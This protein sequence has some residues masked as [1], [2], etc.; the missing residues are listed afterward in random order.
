MPTQLLHSFVS[1]LECS[2]SSKRYDPGYLYNISDAGRPLLVRYD[3]QQLKNAIAVTDLVH[4]PRDIWRYEELL[5]VPPGTEI[6]SLGE[7]STP[8]IPLSR[9]AAKTE[10][11]ELLLKDESR[12]PNGTA[13]ARDLAVAVT[14]AKALGVKHLSMQ[15][16]GNEG[17]TLAAY[18]SRAG[19]NATIVCSEDTPDT[20]IREMT[21]YGA[22]IRLVAGPSVRRENIMMKGIREYGW[23]DIS[24]LREPYRLEGKKTI[25]FELAEQL[26]W[27]LPDV[28]FYPTGNGAGLIAIW[29]AFHELEAIGWI[30]AKRPRMIAVQPAGCAPIV[31]AFEARKVFLE[32][33]W[34]PVTTDIQS[35][36]VPKPFGDFLCLQV[37]QDSGGCGIMISDNE[38]RN[39]L[40]D[41]ALTEGIYLGLEGALCL[42]AYKKILA[43]G[44]IS[45][46]DQVVIFN[47]AKIPEL[48]IPKLAE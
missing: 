35:L 34:G 22:K 25:G 47:S 12:M 41:I 2:F 37:I 38:A 14:M 43:E 26:D 23:F 1:H 45:K 33:P 18:C 28:I 11:S 13:S 5:P 21:F 29:K 30:G 36:R 24:L 42:A 46:R 39:T 8:L 44:Y 32:E 9:F 6:V 40:K 31:K 7:N 10:T 20:V 27:E 4:R 19:L 17:P 15:N 3:L 48:P 16:F